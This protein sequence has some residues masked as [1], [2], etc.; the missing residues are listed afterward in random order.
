[1]E[2]G[3]N[4]LIKLFKST[5]PKNN[6]LLQDIKRIKI[7]PPTTRNVELSLAHGTRGTPHTPIFT[8]SL[9]HRL[10]DKISIYILLK[11]R[12]VKCGNFESLCA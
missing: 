9:L 7:L 1:M 11:I 6:F 12:C 2:K 10:D 8:P 3:R 5:Y 4:Y